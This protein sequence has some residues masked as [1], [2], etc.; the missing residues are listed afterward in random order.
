[1]GGREQVERHQPRKS[2]LV[3]QPPLQRI[4]HRPNR[5]AKVGC[6]LIQAVESLGRIVEVISIE[7]VL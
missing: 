7:V 4:F 3:T 6:Y 5:L 2:L 1:M